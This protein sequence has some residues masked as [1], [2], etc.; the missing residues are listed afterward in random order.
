MEKVV[1]IGTSSVV[2]VLVLSVGT[3]VSHGMSDARKRFH[4]RERGARGGGRGKDPR[5]TLCRE[6]RVAA[7]ARESV[8]RDVRR[9]RE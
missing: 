5:G 1:V 2:V 7:R 6:G 3:D 4:R 8:Q 9:D